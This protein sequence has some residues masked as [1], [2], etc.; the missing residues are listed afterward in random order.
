MNDEQV[1]QRWKEQR[2]NVSP[3]RDFTSKVMSEISVDEQN[4][5][6]PILTGK[7]SAGRYMATCSAIIAASVIGVMRVTFALLLGIL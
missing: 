4:T 2:T 7:Q 5:C 3:A 6:R 1:Y